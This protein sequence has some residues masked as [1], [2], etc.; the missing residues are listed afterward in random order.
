MATAEP[1]SWERRRRPPRVIGDPPRRAGEDVQLLSQLH[2]AAPT[3]GTRGKTRLRLG[4]RQRHR[5][6]PPE[7][8]GPGGTD[9]GWLLVLRSRPSTRNTQWHGGHAVRPPDPDLP[10]RRE[11]V[12]TGAALSTSRWVAEHRRA[13]SNLLGFCRAG[14]KLGV[15]SYQEDRKILNYLQR[16][17]RIE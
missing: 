7:K 17:G 12:L 14:P 15:V 9:C 16:Q 11:N 3:S 2:A 1:T 4:H 5:L 8:P 13:G 6:D 10:T